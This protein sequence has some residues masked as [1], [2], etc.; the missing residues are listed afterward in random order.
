MPVY[1]FRCPRCGVIQMMLFPTYDESE[2]QVVWCHNTTCTQ[3]M[4]GGRCRMEKVLSA[5]AFA[6]KGFSA[7]NG[8]SKEGA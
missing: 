6:I 7:A 5:T 2:R 3:V 4:P 8:Y 1:D